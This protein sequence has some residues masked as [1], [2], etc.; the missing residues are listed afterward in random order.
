MHDFNLLTV[1]PDVHSHFIIKRPQRYVICIYLRMYHQLDQMPLDNIHL[2]SRH[3]IFARHT[4]KDLSAF[5]DSIGGC[6]NTNHQI[7]FPLQIWC[8]FPNPRIGDKI[9]I[10]SPQLQ[11]WLMAASAW[12]SCSTQYYQESSA[13]DISAKERWGK[14][15]GESSKQ[16]CDH[17]LWRVYAALPQGCIS[18]MILISKTMKCR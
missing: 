16:P 14:S 5:I 7:L 4:F 3:L 1:L 17:H 18:R 15:Y 10:V 11:A 6:K 9:F 12:D 2:S 13:I 8:F